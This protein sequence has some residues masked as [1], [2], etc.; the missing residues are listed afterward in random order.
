M[1]KNVNN[2]IEIIIN[3]FKN[4]DFD[5]TINKSTLLLKNFLIMIYCGI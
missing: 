1:N 5:F 3:R 2:E 4:K